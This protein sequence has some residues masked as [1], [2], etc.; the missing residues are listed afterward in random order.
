[1]KHGFRL[2][3]VLRARQ[4]QEDVARGEVLR[5]RNGAARATEVADARDRILASRQAPT[6][7]TARAL[8]AALSARQ[9]M[10]ASLASARLMAK[11]AHARVAGHTE[12]LTEAARRRRTVEKLAERHAELRR[13][14]EQH[15][16]QRA[17]DELATTDRQRDAAR[18]VRP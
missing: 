13:R 11:V 12:E 14:G 15:A 8:V 16:D 6:E 17:L 5:A 4:A 2:A 1:M 9:A 18:T 7:D 3:S 10:A